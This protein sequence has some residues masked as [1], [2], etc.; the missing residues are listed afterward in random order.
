[1]LVCDASPRAGLDLV[2]LACAR[3]LLNARDYR[4]LISAPRRSDLGGTTARHWPARSCTVAAAHD[5][6]DFR[7]AHLRRVPRETLRTVPLALLR[8][9]MLNLSDGNPIHRRTRE[10]A[11]VEVLL[12][13]GARA[14]QSRDH[15]QFRWRI[16]HSALEHP[17]AVSLLDTPLDLNS[18]DV[19]HLFVVVM[20]QQ[21]GRPFDATEL[22]DQLGG[23]LAGGRVVTAGIDPN[24]GTG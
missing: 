13:R 8:C 19:P 22:A 12:R 16:E 17:A 18:L 6:A 10:S 11:F 3:A 21:I 24:A 2:Q 23:Q 14:P 9:A 1:M 5:D 15:C 4:I 20:A 7:E